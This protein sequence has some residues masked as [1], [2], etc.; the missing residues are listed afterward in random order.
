MCLGWLKPIRVPSSLLEEWNGLDRIVWVVTGSEV[1]SV[2]SKL[3][4]TLQNLVTA[5]HKIWDH[6]DLN[7]SVLQSKQ[8]DVYSKE[9]QA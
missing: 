4:K 8:Q 7:M 3:E 9:V 6:V 1:A 2:W 5:T